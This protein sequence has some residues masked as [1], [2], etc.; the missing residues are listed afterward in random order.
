VGPTA[1]LAYLQENNAVAI[2]DVAAASI[3]DIY[4]LGLKDHSLV[5]NSLDTNDRDLNST[6]RTWNKLFG[7]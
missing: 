4:P 1:A 2:L 6:Q 3:V 5:T 7:M